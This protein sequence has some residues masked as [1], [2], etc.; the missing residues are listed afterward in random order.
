M[1]QLC[2]ALE[3]QCYGGSLGD[4]AEVISELEE[5]FPQ[6]AA[7]LEAEKTAYSGAMVGTEK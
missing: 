4:A 3:R 2:S 5:S 6:L 7:R 1:A